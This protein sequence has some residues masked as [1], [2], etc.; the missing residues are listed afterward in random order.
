M[1]NEAEAIVDAE[2]PDDTAISVP[3]HTRKKQKRVSIPDDLACEDIIHDLNDADKFCPH[4]GSALTCI[5]EESHKQLDIEPAKIKVLRHLRKKYACP[6]CEQYL[7]TAS[8][9]AQPIEKSIA[10][11]GLLAISASVST[12]MHCHCI[13]RLLSSNGLVLNWIVPRWLIG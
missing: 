8:K 3:A 13:D 6:C 5:G 10:S 11:P 12:S 7:I 4:D 1:F 9:P 2:E